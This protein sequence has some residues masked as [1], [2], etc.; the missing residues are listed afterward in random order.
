[1]ITDD[2]LELVNEETSKEIFENREV[3][4][5]ETEVEEKSNSILSMFGNLFSFLNLKM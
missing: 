4:E 1:M 3:E 5:E 2:Y